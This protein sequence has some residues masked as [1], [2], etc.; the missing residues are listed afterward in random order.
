MTATVRAAPV[1]TLRAGG[2]TDLIAGIGEGAAARDREDVNPFEPIALLRAARVGAVTVPSA[3]DPPASMREL[4]G[5]VVDL[6]EADPVVAHILRAHFW[7]VR[8]ILRLPESP[9]RHA[10]L[11]AVR[12]GRLI[13]N[14]SSEAGNTAGASDYT[15][16]LTRDRGHW[17]LDGRKA[18]CTGTLF[19]D[20]VAVWATVLEPPGATFEQADRVASV[21]VPTARAG[22][23]V[24]DD[25]DGMGQTRTGTGTTILDAVRVDDAEVLATRSN[26]GGER[27]AADAPYLQ[28]YLQAVMAGIL[29]TVVTDAT[30]LLRGRTRGFSHAPVAEPVHD[31]V[32]HETVGRIASTAWVAETAVLAAADTVEAADAAERRGTPDPELIAAASLA[33]AKVKVHVDETA[34]AAASS[35]FAVGGASAASRARNLDRHWRNIRTLTL[36]NPTAYKAVAI[37]DH[38]VNDAPL[39][40]NAYF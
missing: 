3:D 22:I 30:A 38:V 32:L 37:G 1:A 16:T 27:N 29:R 15:T 33:A 21:M 8:E 6:A 24:L 7:Q 20:L 23:T 34:L 18:Y 35:L 4:L 12:S 9:A 11:E 13:G 17:R 26:R 28:L 36:H 25:W 31:P 19:S 10:L 40:A 2:F 5:L 39:P 14:A